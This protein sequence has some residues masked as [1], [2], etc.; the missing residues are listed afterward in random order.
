MGLLK[1]FLN[2]GHKQ[3]TNVL[4]GVWCVS[5]VVVF[6]VPEPKLSEDEVFAET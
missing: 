6:G 5:C 3:W 2:K 4:K 1:E